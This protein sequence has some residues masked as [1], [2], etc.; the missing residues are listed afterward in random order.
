M[1]KGPVTLRL[2]KDAMST[3]KVDQSL[4]P[5]NANIFEL[6]YEPGVSLRTRISELPPTLTPGETSPL[7]DVIFVDVQ[8]I[9][10]SLQIDAKNPSV[11]R[12]VEW[13]RSEEKDGD[14]RPGISIE[15]SKGSIKIVCGSVKRTDLLHV[16]VVRS[17]HE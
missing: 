14:D 3:K 15:T 13:S 8:D 11:T 17:V 4:L 12:V 16:P 7:A 10:I 6:V 2:L 1:R 9:E 5:R